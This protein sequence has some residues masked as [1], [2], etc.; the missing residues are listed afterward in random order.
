M[1][2]RL[3]GGRVRNIRQ[4]DVL[5]QSLR[6][7]INRQPCILQNIARNGLSVVGVDQLHSRHS[8]KIAATLGSCW[9][10]GKSV[11]GR[12]ATGSVVIRE[13]ECFAA[14]FVDSRDIQRPA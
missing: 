1:K 10:E 12:I 7:G 6:G 11:K 13:E 4:W 8:G 14:A 2:V 9:H 5:Q 3:V